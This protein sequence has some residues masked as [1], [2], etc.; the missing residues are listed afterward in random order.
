MNSQFF[1][2]FCL[3]LFPHFKTVS[4]IRFFWFWFCPSTVFVV[5]AGEK[6][7]KKDWLIGY[8]MGSRTVYI[9]WRHLDSRWITWILWPGLVLSRVVS[10]LKL[11]AQGTRLIFRPFILISSLF[12]CY[13]FLFLSFDTFDT[14]P[15]FHHIISFSFFHQFMMADLGRIQTRHEGRGRA[16][17]FRIDW[18]VE[19]GLVCRWYSHFHWHLHTIDW[20][21]LFAS[22][23]GILF[24]YI[25]VPVVFLDRLNWFFWLFYSY[26]SNIQ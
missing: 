9:C 13:H 12:F 21:I 19:P 5:W 3:I 6:K 11:T 20:F 1:A 17:A 14:L 10:S 18:E 24:V 23:R 8:I 22:R 25:S 15:S 7:N 26:S 2:I 16:W 4:W